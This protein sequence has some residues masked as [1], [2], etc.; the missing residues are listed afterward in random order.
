MGLDKWINSEE[1]EKKEKKKPTEVKIKK[2]EGKQAPESKPNILK[3]MK[4]TLNCPN[5]KCKYQKTVMKKALTDR[6]KIC[7]RCNKEMKVKSI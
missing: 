6:D 3:L 5:S 2:T 4:Y 7:P 1:G